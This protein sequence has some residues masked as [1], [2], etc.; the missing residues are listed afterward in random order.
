MDTGALFMIV[1]PR[2][3]IEAPIVFKCPPRGVP[4]RLPPTESIRFP[5]TWDVTPIPIE[6]ADPPAGIVVL[7]LVEATPTLTPLD[8][9]LEAADP[10]TSEEEPPIGVVHPDTPSEDEGPPTELEAFPFPDEGPPVLDVFPGILTKTGV[11]M[12]GGLPSTLISSF[13]LSSKP[14]TACEALIRQL[15]R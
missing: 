8:A 9:P 10:P 13:T 7:S 12:G 6:V 4:L 1:G 5:E 11:T 14:S 3:A 2:G 15:R